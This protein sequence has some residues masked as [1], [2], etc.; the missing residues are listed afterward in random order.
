MSIFNVQPVHKTRQNIF[1]NNAISNLNARAIR[2]TWLNKDEATSARL[3]AR[4]YANYLQQKRR[5]NQAGRSLTTAWDKY[6]NSAT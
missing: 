3:N 4:A 2:E 6:P 1:R 5:Y